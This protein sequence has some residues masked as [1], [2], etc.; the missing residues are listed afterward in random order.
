MTP[1]TQRYLHNP[2]ETYGD[3]YRACIA[4]LLDLGL[5]DVP[6]FYD[7]I[8]LGMDGCDAACQKAHN[9]T[10]DFLNTYAWL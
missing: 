1:L 3:C 2:P 10:I 5:D 7:R 8:T 6:H 9:A 4:S